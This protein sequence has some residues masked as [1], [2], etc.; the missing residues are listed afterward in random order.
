MPLWINPEPIDVASKPR[1][2][3]KIGFL[4]KIIQFSTEKDIFYWSA[5]YQ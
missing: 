5:E 1:Q 3:M 2:L 4:I